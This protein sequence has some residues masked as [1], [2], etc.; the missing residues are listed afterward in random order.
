MCEYNSKLIKLVV[1]DTPKTIFGLIYVS[2]VYIWVYFQY[3]PL[4]F[5]ILWSVLQI[6]F[7]YFRYINAK[8]L[9]KY[10]NNKDIKKL[11]FHTR[12]FAIIVIYSSILWSLATILGAYFAPTPYE[13]V[14][15]AMIMGIVTS[16]VI[17]L[18]PI[19]NVFLVYFFVMILSQLSIML[20]FSTHA[21]IA[22]A[23][24]LLI[25][26]LVIILH[27]K[28]IYNNY[29]K[30]IEIHETLESN[31]S[32]LRELSITDSLTKVYN[33]RY[34]FE[35]TKILLSISKR[36]NNNLS[37]LMIDID[38][39]KNVNDTYGHQI[40][41][42]VLIQLSKKIKSMIRDSDIFAR[43][44]GEEFGLVLNNTSLDNA[45]IS[46]EKIRIAIEKMNFKNNDEIIDITVSIGCSTINDVITTVEDLY[47]EA[48]K[49]LY[50]AKELGRN[51]VEY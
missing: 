30:D 39:F 9:A 20:Y 17:S 50:L 10:N 7:I 24:F 26:M 45:K 15:L 33:R 29:L 32:E 34:F 41:D 44:G 27:A 47:K 16:S 37:F 49:K 13:F 22:I 40:G 11:K 12:F 8:K 19:F 3:I 5:L 21:H 35:S 36:E 48:D 18:T 42:Y 4:K 25:Y 14:S 23:I 51:R 1:N 31:V 38:Y 6:F 2:S 28:S 43:L 46:A